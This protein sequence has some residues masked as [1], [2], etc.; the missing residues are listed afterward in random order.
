MPIVTIQNV[1][2]QSY[3]LFLVPCQHFFHLRYL[4]HLDFPNTKTQ[5]DPNNTFIRIRRPFYSNNRAHHT[6]KRLHKLFVRIVTRIEQSQR[7]K[8]NTERFIY[9]SN[10]DNENLLQSTAIGNTHT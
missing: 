6:H 5:N 2:S 9:T 8:G 4:N 10:I 1:S 3:I 7:K